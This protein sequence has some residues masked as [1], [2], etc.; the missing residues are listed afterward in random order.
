MSFLP[1]AGVTMH[2]G[3]DRGYTVTCIPRAEEKIGGQI[4]RGK[5]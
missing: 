4:Y 5:L 1:T 3:V 2:I